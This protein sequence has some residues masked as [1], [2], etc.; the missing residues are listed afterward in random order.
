MKLTKNEIFCI[1]ASARKV[2][3]IQSLGKQEKNTQTKT[4]KTQPCWRIQV[5]LL[6][7]RSHCGGL[8]SHLRD[9]APIP[10]LGTWAKWNSINGKWPNTEHT[11]SLVIWLAS[12]AVNSILFKQRRNLNEH[13]YISPKSLTAVGGKEGTLFPSGGYGL[14]LF[15]LLLFC[16]EVKTACKTS[17]ESTVLWWLKQPFSSPSPTEVIQH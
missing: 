15:Y 14:I 3:E 10:P 7:N 5:F 17:S 9:E 8:S 1:W 11:A 13:C 16:K 12:Q 2:K 4:K 6:F